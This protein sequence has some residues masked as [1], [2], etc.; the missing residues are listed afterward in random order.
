MSRV[1]AFAVYASGLAL[2]ERDDEVVVQRLVELAEGDT[3]ELLDARGLLSTLRAHPDQ[4]ERAQRLIE[5]AITR[6]EQA[7]RTFADSPRVRE[8]ARRR[9][10]HPR[11]QAND[12]CRRDDPPRSSGSAD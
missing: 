12:P 7:R 8:D 2:L 11:E 5:R 1:T 3:G 4:V 9:S 10:G 6:V